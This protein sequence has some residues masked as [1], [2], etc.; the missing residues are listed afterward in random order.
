MKGRKRGKSTEGGTE[1]FYNLLPTPG[2]GTCTDQVHTSTLLL[3]EAA[4]AKPVL[5]FPA[6][7]KQR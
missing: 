5:P 3:G 7:V 4:D 6:S 1:S 2:K